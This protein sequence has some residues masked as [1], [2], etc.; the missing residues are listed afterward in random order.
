MSKEKIS[1]ISGKAIYV[2]A[3]VMGVFQIYTSITRS[4][5]PVKLQNMHLMFALVLIFGGSIH[6]LF[7]SNKASWHLILPMFGLVFSL[8]TTVYIQINYDDMILRVGRSTT[9]DLIIGGI[10][11]VTILVATAESFGKA[12]PILI[13]IGIAYMFTGPYF[14]GIF[15]HG[16]FSLKRVIA[17]LVTSFSGCY[18]SLLN[19]SAT[20]IALF[21]IFGGFMTKTGAGNFFVKLALCIGGKFRAGA[22]ITAVVASGL[23]GAI[24]GS[25]SAVVATTGVFTLPL[26][27][28]RKYEPQFAS[29]VCS[30]ASTGGMILPPVM[31]VGAFIMAELTGTT[32]AAVAF[33]AIVPALLYYLMIISVVII[34]AKKMNLQPIPSEELPRLGA[35]LREG[36]LFLIP[37]L[38]IVYCLSAGFSTTKAALY[39]IALLVIVYLIME[40]KKDPKSLKRFS[41]YRVLADG[42]VDGAKSCIGIATCMAAVGI[43]NN[44]VVSTGLANRL[45]NL[46]L[47]MGNE[48]Q[49]LSLIITMLLTLLFGMGVP[50][51]AAYIILAMMAA[52]ALVKIGLPVL[53]VHLF[54]FYFAAIANLTPPVA[55]ATIIASKM[56]G[57]NYV[58]ACGHAMKMC[59]SAFIIPFIFVFRPAMMLDGSPLEVLD[60][61]GT[62]IFGLLSFAAFVECY[63]IQKNKVWEQILLLVSSVLLLLPLSGLYSLLGG[64]CLVIVVC[65]QFIIGKRNQREVPLSE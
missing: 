4:M 42:L 50:T 19:T 43:L 24:N 26:M 45:V 44:C 7:S 38:S 48:G 56:A 51:T 14:S 23:M 5:D 57:A 54:I 33:A 15:Y 9:L 8:I 64:I 36:A 1:I 59:L 55:P 52:P 46:I 39:S 25:A 41:T 20:F 22:G 65:H 32:Y 49:L 10:L 34:R 12:I 11:L 6:K 27:T 37:L 31:G 60:V 17:S 28:A 3:F 30:T 18:G 13:V 16:G 35:T 21:M 62:A 61:V 2:I 63:M 29:A 40:V 53:P 47:R 58:R